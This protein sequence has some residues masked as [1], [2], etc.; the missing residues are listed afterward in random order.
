MVNHR[1]GIVDAFLDVQVASCIPLVDVLVG[2]V[3][4]LRDPSFDVHALRVIVNL[5][6][7]GVENSKVRLSISSIAHSPL[8]TPRVLHGAVVN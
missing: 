1:R 4:Q 8:P 6:A 3:S 7:P 2:H 5:L